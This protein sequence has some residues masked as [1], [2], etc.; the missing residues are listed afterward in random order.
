MDQSR[1]PPQFAEIYQK[2]LALKVAHDSGR[3]NDSDYQ[4]EILSL[5]FTDQQGQ[6]WWLSGEGEWFWSNGTTW[7]PKDP[8]LH[9]DSSLPPPIPAMFGQPPPLSSTRLSPPPLTSQPPRPKKKKF[10]F[11]LIPALIVIC[12]VVFAIGA[13]L[14]NRADRANLPSDPIGDRDSEE[15]T[16]DQSA[17]QEETDKPIV[18]VALSAQQQFLVEDIGWPDAFS[19]SE[20]ETNQGNRVRLETWLYYPESASYTFADGDFYSSGTVEIIGENFTPTPHHPDQ[21]PMGSSPQQIQSL[22]AGHELKKINNS[23]N[24]LEGVQLYVCQQ[25]IL[26]FQENRLFHVEALAFVPEGGE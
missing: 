22:L 19:V 14:V 23:K 18:L 11:I 12:L 24:F 20:V 8:P 3:L 1:L 17:Y 9:S 16:N 6:S 7:V 5:V 15:T 4:R 10:L 13:S 2:Y 25:L 26:S 21:F